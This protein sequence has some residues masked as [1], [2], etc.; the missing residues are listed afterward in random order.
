MG[1]ADLDVEKTEARIHQ[2][3]HSRTFFFFLNNNTNDNNNNNDDDDDEDDDDDDD[4]KQDVK[5]REKP[6]GR[7]F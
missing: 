1:D 3:F 5:T 6:R 4:D 7:C 2:I